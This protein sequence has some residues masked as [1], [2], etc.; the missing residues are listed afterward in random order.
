MSTVW[1][2]H[3][4]FT[5]SLVDVLLG[6]FS[7]LL[8]KDNVAGTFLSRFLCRHISSIPLSV[9]LGGRILH[10]M[11]CL[12]L[13]FWGPANGFSQVTV[14][15]CF[16]QATN[17][18]SNFS[19]GSPTFV[20]VGYHHGIIGHL[21]VILENMSIQVLFPSKNIGMSFYYWVVRI[22]YISWIQVF[23]HINDLQIHSSILLIVFSPS[24]GMFWNTEVLGFAKLKI[25]YILF[26]HMCLYCLI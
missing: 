9:H 16:P 19:T 10:D 13:T 1:I 12:C 24:D 23:Y 7:F 22:L 26:C 6:C 4:S 20:T 14:P 17:E 2:D 11:E 25:I 18:N 5:H 21:H 3:I 15:F 8:I